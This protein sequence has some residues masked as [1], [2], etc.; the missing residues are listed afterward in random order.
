[1]NPYKDINMSEI[2]SPAHRELSIVAAAKSFVLLKNEKQV[3]PIRNFQKKIAVSAIICDLVIPQ[4][5]K[6]TT[7]YDWLK[8][9]EGTLLRFFIFLFLHLFIPPDVWKKCL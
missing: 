2:Q 6:E 7:K 1:M 8:G 9:L 5:Y 4:G 3:L